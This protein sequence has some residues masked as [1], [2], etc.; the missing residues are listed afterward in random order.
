[1]QKPSRKNSSRCC[2]GFM[3]GRG[4]SPR[5]GTRQ[6]QSTRVWALPPAASRAGPQ[7][8]PVAAI[9]CHTQ[10]PQV[11]FPPCHLCAVVCT[12]KPAHPS[13]L[14]APFLTVLR[15]VIILPPQGLQRD[16]LSPAQGCLSRGAP[17][18]LEEQGQWLAHLCPSLNARGDGDT[19]PEFTILPLLLRWHTVAWL[20]LGWGPANENDGRREERGWSPHSSPNRDS[21]SAFLACFG[22]RA[23]RG[24]EAPRAVE[25]G[26]RA[27]FGVTSS[28]GRP[29]APG[30]ARR[31]R[32]KARS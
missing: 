14:E 29:G 3:E 25:R 17:A 6:S 31:P 22:A 19:S 10:L 30:C 5:D 9:P 2:L 11:T 7:P 32:W 8:S 28:R 4:H 24:G 13:P 18:N 1:M 15:K 21:R 20:L 23:R 12:W 27:A 16:L 26:R